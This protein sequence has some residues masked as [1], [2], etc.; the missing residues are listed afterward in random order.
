MPV[1]DGYAVCRQLKSNRDLRPIPVLMIS[2]GTSEAEVVAGLDAGADDYISKPFNVR[3]VQSRVRS[4]LRVK[5]L[6]DECI[7]ANRELEE[8]KTAAEAANRSKSEFLSNMSHEIRTPMTA[9]LGF[10]DILADSVTR[11][12]NLE[13]VATITRNGQHLLEILNDILDLSKIEGEKLMSRALNVGRVNWWP[14]L[15]R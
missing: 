5:E 9:I 12:E 14:T 2:A 1:M 11:P 8:A 13:A 10:T 15:H 4:A 7:A 3:I 6:H